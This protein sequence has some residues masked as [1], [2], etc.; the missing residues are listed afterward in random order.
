MLVGRRHIPSGKD[1]PQRVSRPAALA[2]LRQVVVAGQLSQMSFDRIAVRPRGFLDLLDRD[3]SSR[4][5]EF[6]DLTRERRQGRTQSLFFFNLRS[7]VVFL[8]DHRPKEKHKPV[9]PVLL[10]FA[11]RL[12]RATQREVIVVL[13]SLDHA[14]HRTVRNVPVTRTQ[15]QESRED[16]RQPAIAVFERMDGQEHHNE[17]RNQYQRML[18]FFADR[19]IEPVDEFLHP[20]GSFEWRGSLKH[21]AQTLAIGTKGFAMIRNLLVV[22]T[23]LLILAAVFEKNAVTLFDMVIRDCYRLEALKN[24]VHRIGVACDFLL[25]A[26]CKRF[27]L[28]TGKQLVYFPVAES[29]AFDT[30]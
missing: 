22:T 27:G 18:R 24:H 30:G 7:E 3:F 8:L 14:L 19:L 16:T 21:D 1:L 11:N 23:M 17:N 20:A 26:A 9:F 4:L 2:D 13:V 15:Q 10:S 28:H 29:C 5:C 12:L 25:I 6:Q